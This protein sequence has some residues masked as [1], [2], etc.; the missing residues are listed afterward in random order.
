MA[1]RM[2]SLESL[3]ICF[4][5]FLHSHMLKVWE[6]LSFADTSIYGAVWYGSKLKTSERCH[7][8]KEYLFF[9]VFIYCSTE[10]IQFTFEI[11]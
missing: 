1:A 11:L 6:F 8:C 9:V 10:K 7:E 5:K 4:R 3:D 2:A